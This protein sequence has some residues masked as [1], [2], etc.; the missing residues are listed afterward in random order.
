MGAPNVRKWA[1]FWGD[2]IHGRRIN[3]EVELFEDADGKVS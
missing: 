2:V 3:D 1:A